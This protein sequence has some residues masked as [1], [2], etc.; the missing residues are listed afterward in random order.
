MIK[1]FRHIRKSLIE[2]NKMGKYF[3]Y[4]IGEILLVVIG[5]LIALQINNWNEDQKSAKQEKT[6]YCKISEDLQVDIKNIDSALVSIDIR[7]ERTKKFMKNLL[8]IQDD[9]AV[10]FK[11]FIPT[12]RYYKFLPTKAA[13][14]DITSSGKLEKL[15]NQPLK[16]SILSHYTEQENALKIV[17]INY[18]KLV[19]K[20]F[21]LEKFADFGFQEVPQYQNIF[22]AELQELLTSKQW[23]ENPDNELFIKIK[24]VMILNMIQ[25][26]REKE[27]LK[28]IKADA[29][30]LNSLLVENCN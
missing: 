5:I 10:I 18:N 24:D 13:I 30:E 2:K 28:G 22:D 25:G 21:D 11:D 16:K 19:D 14:V 20:L 27:L 26:E 4:V 29:E 9:K 23:Q 8:K 17:D 6:Y 15:R 1:F 12:F 3:K 7:L